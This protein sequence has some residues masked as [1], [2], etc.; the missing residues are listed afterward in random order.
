MN[1]QSRLKRN[2]VLQ[3]KKQFKGTQIF[4]HEDFTRLNQLVLT[5]VRKKMPDE[6]NK[7]WSRNGHIF[8]KSKANHIH[9]VNFKGNKNWI[10]LPWP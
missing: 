10:D 3:N 1:F 5:C 7:V 2:V 8:Y 4:V 9:E 6:V